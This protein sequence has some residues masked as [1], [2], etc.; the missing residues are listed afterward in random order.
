MLL[1]FTPFLKKHAL[2][3]LKMI[4]FSVQ[5]LLISSLYIQ[6]ISLANDDL[7]LLKNAVLQR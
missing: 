1:V 7:T 4:A 6:V 3:C 5:S 2:F